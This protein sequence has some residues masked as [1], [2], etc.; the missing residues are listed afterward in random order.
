MITEAEN[1]EIS[2]KSARQ[3]TKILSDY[4]EEDEDT[5]VSDNLD[6]LG[7]FSQF[8]P[9]GKYSLRL[10]R[11]SK[12][13]MRQLEDADRPTLGSRYYKHHSV[14]LNESTH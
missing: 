10:I 6:F 14:P 3:K 12:D 11:D 2:E 9:D 5:I 4:L 13:S 8:V 7:F 1:E